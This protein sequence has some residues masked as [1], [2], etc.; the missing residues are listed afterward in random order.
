MRSGILSSPE[1][2]S[3]N[4]LTVADWRSEC[5]QFHAEHSLECFLERGLSG[6]P[7][8]DSQRIVAQSLMVAAIGTVHEVPAIIQNIGVQADSNPLLAGRDID[9]RA[10]FSF[11]EV[12]RI[13]MCAA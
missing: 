13:D 7:D 3:K 8:K 5:P 12:V 11:A 1:A 6:V 4:S 10:M 9:H 2:A